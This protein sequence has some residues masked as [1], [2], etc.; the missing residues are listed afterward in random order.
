MARGSGAN[1]IHSDAT[2]GL[3]NVFGPGVVIG[4]G[5]VIGSGNIF[6]PFVV[7]SGAVS[8]GDHNYISAHAV[9]GGSSRQRLRPEMSRPPVSE[10][11]RIEI[12]DDNLLFEHVVIHQPLGALTQIC[13]RASIGAHSHVGHDAKLGDEVI[14]SPNVLLGGF[15]QIG[16]GANFGLGAA[17]HNRV[18]VGDYVMVGMNAAVTTHV[19]PAVTVA[20]I[21]AIF[22]GINN[23]GLDR[24]KL[25]ASQISDLK[26]WIE[27][28][29]QPADDDVAQLIEAWSTAVERSGRDRP[30]L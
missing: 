14:L 29:V 12:G 7:L 27:H 24:S 9:I 18:V 28:L 22:R 25:T 21:P 16:T 5:A 3:G 20:G 15:T 10:N 23:V 19:R 2:I 1:N 11:P 17:V 4:P 13:S 26:H 30:P 6:G 8:I